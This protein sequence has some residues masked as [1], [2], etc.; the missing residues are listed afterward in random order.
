MGDHGMLLK[1]SLD[2][3]ASLARHICDTPFALIS[4]AGEASRDAS[5]S[6]LAIAQRD[7]FIVPDASTDDRFAELPIVTGDEHIRFY[8]GA[9]LVTRDGQALGTLCVMDRVPR[10]LT[11]AQQDALRVLGRQLMVHLELRRHTREPCESETLL[12][13]LITGQQ[14]TDVAT[15]RLATATS[16]LTTIVE[17]EAVARLAGR[18]AHDFNNVLT[19]ILGYSELLLA[20]RR[21]DDPERADI[22]EIQKAGD[23]AARM[24]GQLLAFSRKQII[25]PTLL[26]LNEVVSSMLERLEPLIGK[27]VKVVVIQGGASAPVEAD[28]R[29]VEQVIMNLAVNARDAM[30]HGGTLTIETDDIELD[31]RD[32]TTHLDL[33]PGPHVL[34]TVTDTGA[35]M[36]PE[37]QARLFEPFFT[38]KEVSGGTGLGM[39][40]VHGIV[41]RSGGGVGVSSEV[42]RGTSFKVYWPRADRAETAVEP[43]A[44]VRARGGVETVVLVEETE[45]LRGL[46][47]R[48]LEGYGYTVLVAANAGEA[49]R[50]F[51]QDASIDVLL[52]DRLMPGAGG[53]ELT[54]ALAERRRGLKIIYMCGYTEDAVTHQA[55]LQPGVSFLHKPFSPETLGR[56]IREILDR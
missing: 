50:L 33:T 48:L 16:R 12:Q 42:G 18:V 31:D 10:R 29:Q 17:M 38:T 20:G 3:L 15:R 24:T 1:Q 51:E 9:P 56:E 45:V 46:V 28:R 7:L 41:L 34:L 49:L 25:V 39:A 32:V 5:F 2:D 47:K 21:P 14:Q 11:A 13:A 54:R 55:L 19:T 40:T 6:R 44:A 23:S 35:G 52:T 4:L 43:A 8:A 30:P 22:L 53:L 36:T 37:V 27:A 26:D